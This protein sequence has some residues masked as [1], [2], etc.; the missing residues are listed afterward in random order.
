MSKQRATGRTA[1]HRPFWEEMLPALAHDFPAPAGAPVV[2]ADMRRVSLLGFGHFTN[3]MYGNLATSLAPYFV[4]DGRLTAPVAGV[5]ILVYLGG[6]SVLQPLFGIISDRSGRR[7]FAVAGPV[8]IGTAM[9]LLIIAPSAWVIF[10]LV[11]V[12]GVGTAAFHPQ[13]ASMVNRM[14]GQSRGWAMSIFSMGGNLGYGLGPV[15][16]ATMF[17]IGNAWTILLAIPGLLCTALLFKFA[18]PARSHTVQSTGQSLREARVHLR[19]LGLIV[20][21]IAIRSGAMSGVIFLAPLYFH[22][23][24]LPPAW[25]SYGSSIFLLAGAITGLYT[26]RLSDRIGRRPVV[27]WSLLAAAPLIFCFGLLP[28]LSSW[29]VMALAGCAILASNSVTVVQ[30]QEF[31]PNNTGLAG[32]LT[33]GLGFGLSGVITF[34]VSAVSKHAGPRDTLFMVAA[35]PLVAAGCAFLTAAHEPSA[36][37]GRA[38]AGVT[39]I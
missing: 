19:P 2:Q 37:S 35:L 6:S 12:G 39:P 34:V 20:L 13:G 25:G 1:V 22:S 4:L 10:A 32:G 18:P 23:Q 30:A 9:S 33:L 7:W 21:V 36:E 15:L 16:A 8:W 11:A 5:M 3:D 29:P 24:G 31:L 38:N 17:A 28:G 14:A 26:G 27:V